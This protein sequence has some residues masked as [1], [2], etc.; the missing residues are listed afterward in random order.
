MI[1]NEVASCSFSDHESISV[2]INVSKPKRKLEVKTFRSLK[3]YTLT[4]LC[5]RLIDEI[6]RLNDILNTDDVNIQTE[7]LSNIFKSSLDSYAPIVTSS[8]DDK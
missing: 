6:P 8:L 1:R 3:N 7:I 2:E 4:I 5:N